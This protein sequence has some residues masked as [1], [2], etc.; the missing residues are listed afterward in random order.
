VV[1]RPAA[2][3]ADRTLQAA[4]GSKVPQFRSTV[5]DFAVSLKGAVTSPDFAVTAAMREA[6][7]HRLTARGVVLDR[8]T[9]D[10]AS[11]LIDRLVATQAVQGALGARAAFERTLH[12]DSTLARARSLLV[13]VNSPAALLNRTPGAGTK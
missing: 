8:A 10:A 7:Y 4:L 11:P 12:S 6:L 13:G 9:Y 3:R 1:A 5:A 2:S